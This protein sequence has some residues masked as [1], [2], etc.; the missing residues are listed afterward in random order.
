MYLKG[1]V[2][3]S[4]RITLYTDQNIIS[5]DL[6]NTDTPKQIILDLQ[7]EGLNISNLDYLYK[8]LRIVLYTR[9]SSIV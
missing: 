3:K 5:F 9:F 7:I 4:N 6:M 2:K 1:V 8:L